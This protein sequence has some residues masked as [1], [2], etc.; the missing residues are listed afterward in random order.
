M[1]LKLKSKRKAALPNYPGVYNTE[2]RDAGKAFLQN[3]LILLQITPQ[4]SGIYRTTAI[5]G[6]SDF[7]WITKIYIYSLN[8]KII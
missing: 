8:C 1:F 6:V 2:N 7:H 5:E 4:A 3:R